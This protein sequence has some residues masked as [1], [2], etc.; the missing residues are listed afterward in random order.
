MPRKLLG[1]FLAMLKQTLIVSAMLLCLLRSSN[2]DAQVADSQ[3]AQILEQVVTAAGGREACKQAADFRA[4]G[5]FSL[6]S[7]GEVTETGNAALI[8]SGLKRFRLTATLEN[9]TRTWVWKDGVG[10]LLARD[11][12]P[13]PIGL[14]NLSA[15]EGITLPVL[16]VVALL[17][18]HSRSVR[19]L[20]TVTLD[21]KE[22]YR[23]RVTRTPTEHKERLVLGRDSATTDVL[24]DRQTLFV[25]AIEDTIYPNSHT[26][27][28]YQH[29][30]AYGD[31]RA[32][33]GAQ[34][35]FSI[36]EK[37]ADQTTWGLQ[38]DTFTAT[39]SPN[40]SEFQLN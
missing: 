14:H 15:L 22:V 8:G 19:L 6:H 32:V 40:G 30:V 5:T 39:A 16:K 7:G 9:E 21:G 27:E 1:S 38:L 13:D 24:V 37:I 20:E 3:G 10:F 26:R 33:N 23:L 2:M 17:D 12:Q 31:Y 36:K 4:S 18:S 29:S 34:V 11:K 28:S 35:P 25:I